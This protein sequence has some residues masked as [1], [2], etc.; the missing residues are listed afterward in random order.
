MFIFLLFVFHH[1][2]SS[3]PSICAL[4]AEDSVRKAGSCGTLLP[5]LEARLVDSNGKDVTEAGQPGEIW[6]RG[7]N[8]M[9]YVQHHYIS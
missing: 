8:I 1:S 2:V 7:M 6:V 5:N 9:K 3:R 4:R